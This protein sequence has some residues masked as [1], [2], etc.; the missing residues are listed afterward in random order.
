M[1]KKRK[2]APKEEE[3]SSEDE[4]QLKLEEPSDQSEED[5][6][7]E[8]EEDSDDEEEA[9]YGEEASSE[10]EEEVE[11]AKSE[12]EEEE[13]DEGSRRETIRKL[14]EPFG[15]DQLIEIFKEAALKDSSI[16]A[17]ISQAAESES[18]HR[19]IFVHGLGWDATTE[20]LVSVFK[21]YGEIEECN[22]VTD[23]V[24]GKSKGYG[25]V[26]FKTRA[27]ARKALKEPQKKIGNRMTACQLSSFGPVPNHP[28]PDPTGRKIYVANVGSHVNPEKLRAFFAKFGEIEEGPL[29]YDRITGKLKGFAIF[30]YKTTDG[31]KK[32]LEEPI[33]LFEGCSL[34]CKRAVEGLQANKNKTGLVPA[35]PPDLV[36]TYGMGL[37]PG[38]VSQNVN[39][40]ALMGQNA[41]IGVLNPALGTSL[42]QMGLSPSVASGLS[43]ANRSGT[44]PPMGLGGGFGGQQGINS[45]SPSVI[46]SYGSHAALQG[47]GAYQSA[48]FGQSSAAA[49]SQSG[50]GSIGTL[51]S[52]FGR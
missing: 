16:I 2:P 6:E 26:L 36:L 4:E 31:C 46:G 1:A 9:E 20:T 40:A 3:P 18:V 35:L 48:Q 34:Q 41:G 44:T 15:K 23:K 52:Y 49:R 33:K 38:M 28:I 25:F 14:L 42:N 8:E 22:V 43:S 21:Q 51:P 27:G 12:S 19:K 24:T 37:N 50:I 45:I 17:R 11:E 29:G 47:L 5:E 32:A 39:P 10:E 7:E 13:E 30:V